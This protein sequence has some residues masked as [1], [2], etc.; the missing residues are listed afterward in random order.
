MIFL[1]SGNTKFQHINVKYNIDSILTATKSKFLD[2][3]WTNWGHGHSPTTP[4]GSNIHSDN[5]KC[6]ASFVNGSPSYTPFC[7]GVPTTA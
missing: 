5:K 2:T 3:H 6:P 4:V 7:S 1:K